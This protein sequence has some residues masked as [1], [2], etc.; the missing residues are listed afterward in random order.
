MAKH[1]IDADELIKN[2][3]GRIEIRTEQMHKATNCR[4][5]DRHEAVIMA[6]ASVLDNVRRMIEESDG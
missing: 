2:L 3:E 6:Y 4:D 1:L 5:Y